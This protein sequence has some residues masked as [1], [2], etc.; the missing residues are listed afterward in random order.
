MVDRAGSGLRMNVGIEQI[1]RGDPSVDARLPDLVSILP[2]RDQVAPEIDSVIPEPR[3]ARMLD[4]FL[5]PQIG[6]TDMLMPGT[7]QTMFDELQG[8]VSAA[9]TRDAP[10]LKA[11]KA[12]LADEQ[13]T[14]NLLQ[15]YRT[16]LVG[17]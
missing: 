13:L 3:L 16:T 9:N 2:S 11:A 17:A 15:V 5:T 4:A 12:L 7:F 14:R 8:L 1:I 10:E 6:E